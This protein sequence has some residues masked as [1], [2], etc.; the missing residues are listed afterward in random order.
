MKIRIYKHPIQPQ[1]DN[2]NLGLFRVWIGGVRAWVGAARGTKGQGSSLEMFEVPKVKLDK[3][4]IEHLAWVQGGDFITPNYYY[5][6][7]QI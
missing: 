6:F 7:Q 1:V 3:P 5:Y 2:W 4:T